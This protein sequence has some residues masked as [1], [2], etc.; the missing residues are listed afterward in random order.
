LGISGN[1][2]SSF[3]S[4]NFNCIKNASVL[5]FH[6]GHSF[7]AD[8]LARAVEAGPQPARPAEPAPEQVRIKSTAALVKAGQRE[9]V[10]RYTIVRAASD[11]AWVPVEGATVE[12]GVSVR[13]RVESEQYGRIELIEFDASGKPRLAAAVDAAPGTPCDLPADGMRFENP[14]YRQFILRLSGTGSFTR[15]VL[16]IKRP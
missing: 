9:P 8:A 15:I 1:W 2:S 4:E 12:T 16:N 14:G 6:V 11:G 13:F 7:R 10:L 5:P 3:I